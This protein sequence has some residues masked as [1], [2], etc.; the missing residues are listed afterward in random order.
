MLIHVVDDNAVNC[1]I[2]ASIASRLA[3]DIRVESFIDPVVGLA[4][5]QQAMPDLVVVDYMMP[6]LDGFQYATRIRALPGGKVVPIVMIT[7]ATYRAIRH[8][9]L[10][11]GV[12]DFLTKP[13]D[14]QEV[15]ARLTN[16]L[17]LRR[18]HTQ[19]QDRSRWLA[20]EVR[21]ATEQV[22]HQANHD[23]LTALP[24]RA[25]FL[26]K[27]DEALSSASRAGGKVALLYLD[28]DGFKAINDSFGHSTGDV[29]LLNV[30]TA[31]RDALK[32]G[33]MAARL[34]GDEFAVLQQSVLQPDGAEA[35]AMRLTQAVR[36]ACGDAD[37]RS[38]VDVSLGI[39][40]YPDHAETGANLLQRADIA[41]YRAKK[42]GRGRHCFFH[43]E[44]D[45]EQQE[46]RALE[47]D[48]GAALAENRLE[49]HYQPQADAVSGEIVGCEAL[50]RWTDP[51]RGVVPPSTF[52]PLAEE[53]GLIRPLGEW[54]LR[55]A[56]AEAVTWPN[57][58]RVGVNLSPLQVRSDLPAL[59]S[60][61]LLETG[62]PPE[63]LELEI[64]EGLLIKEPER[65]IA[66]LGQ[67][68]ALGVTIALDDFGTGYS[69][70][71]YL[72]TFEFDRIKIDR[73][74][75]AQLLRQPEA[76]AIIRAIL[77]MTRSLCVASI[78]EGIETVQQLA[79]LQREQCQEVQGYLIGR[80]MPATAFADF[81][82]DAKTRGIGKAA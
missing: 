51:L 82:K 31:I 60:S 69:S 9:A 66:V 46:R 42:E 16:L 81:I 4:S 20:D 44:M 65:A 56:C 14:K 32:P 6:E 77:A 50:A 35:L 48:L 53:C 5:S 71:S 52:V 24:N 55:T 10:E 33:E 41:L 67:L 59:V 34:G 78:A 8:Q 11:L 61:I 45:A 28:L 39:G 54:V 15:R 7:A 25:N 21:K 27:L 17:A 2:F 47:R 49:V 30:G 26:A 70:L 12:T 13:I 23:G 63:R 40:L 75:V 38:S 57:G 80:P 74:F 19:L 68:K 72:Q 73:S 18:A 1:E 64:T 79:A 76:E 29:L 36:T 43:P 58:L 37:S 22:L 62:L 3:S